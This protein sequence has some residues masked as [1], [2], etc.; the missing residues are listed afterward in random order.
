[1]NRVIIPILLF[2]LNAVAFAQ[3]SFSVDASTYYDDNLYR[4]PEA[5]SDFLNQIGIKLNYSPE[6][7]N[8]S[9]FINGNYFSFAAN[10]T[11]NFLLSTIGT[12]YDRS[13]GS[14]DQHEFFFGADW[15]WRMD[16]TE[17]DYYD[18]NQLYAFSGLKLN[19]NYFYLKT[20]YNFRYRKYSNL[21]ELNNSRH[22]AFVQLNKSFATKTS[23]ILEGDLGY[24]SFAGQVLANSGSDD[25]WGHG[26][27]GGMHAVYSESSIPSMSHA[28]LLARVAQSL[29]PRVGVYVQYR[30][31]ISL[32]N[33]TSY[34]NVE[35]YF[36]DE[37]LFD[38]PFSYS[39][40]TVS[41]QLTWILPWQMKLQAGGGALAKEY[42][43]EQAFVSADDSLGSGGIRKDN[44]T[45]F[46]ANLSKN[47]FIGKTWLKL[48][49]LTFEYS[50]IDNRSNSYW[51]DYKNGVSGINLQWKF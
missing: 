31:Q 32:T 50:F 29:H 38:D 9:Y 21:S 19:L 33:E 10:N 23:L 27:R 46:Y 26:R 7:T 15:T 12:N 30:K 5:E 44:R 43:S 17:Y 16:Q 14:E 11:R 20:G 3:T 35:S 25:M 22:Y 49:K 45:F 47:F 40:E 41:G 2:M 13:F 8:F 18:Y 34:Q 42:I 37:E 48:L 24:K 51:Y 1:M 36:Q 6:E 39:S 28:I 4:S